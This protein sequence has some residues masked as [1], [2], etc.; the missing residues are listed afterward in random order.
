[1]NLAAGETYSEW[2]LGLNPR[3]LAPVLILDGAVHIESNDIMALLDERFP[4][5]RLFPADR[6]TEIADLCCNG[7]TPCISIC[8][9]SASAS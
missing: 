5:P 2:F 4:G 6:A 9:G 8:G 7:K 3:G 1:M